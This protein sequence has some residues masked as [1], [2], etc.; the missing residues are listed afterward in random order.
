MYKAAVFSGGHVES[1]CHHAEAYS[2]LTPEEKEAFDLLVSGHVNEDGSFTTEM[3]HATKNILFVRHAESQY[4][5]R[6][7]YHL[8]SDLTN[9]GEVQAHLLA[10]HI[11]HLNLEGY[12][13]FVS[14]F[15]RCLK[16]ARYIMRKT[17]MCFVVCPELGE[18]SWTFP[19]SGLDIQTMADAFWEMNW[20]GLDHKD[21]IHCPKETDAVFVQK[22]AG[23]LVNLPEKSLIV[24]H[25]TPIMTLI[26]LALGAQVGRIP[27]WDGSIQNASMSHITH[28]TLQ[29]LSRTVSL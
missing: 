3:Q 26:E 1:G 22:L 10:N 14:P 2:R 11:H 7:T 8:D 12:T 9:D 15:K 18:V 13:G 5:V 20:D 28:G 17:G 27:Q 21:T 24:S 4:N 23:L 25:G 16:T 29:Y 19:E 6:K